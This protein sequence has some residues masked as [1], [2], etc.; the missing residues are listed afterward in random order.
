[1]KCLCGK[2]LI[3]GGDHS[4][5]HDDSWMM[6]TNYHCPECE[7]VVMVYHPHPTANHAN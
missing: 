3:W 7:R 4:D 6:E 5:D 2:E 1:M